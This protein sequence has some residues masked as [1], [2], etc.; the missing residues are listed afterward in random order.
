MNFK[1]REPARRLFFALWPAD[2]ERRTLTAAAAAAVAA[3]GGRAVPEQNLH[4]TL[5]FLGRVPGGR[6]SELAQLGRE[7]AAGWAAGPLVLGFDALAHWAKPQLLCAIGIEEAVGAQSFAAA[8][9]RAAVSE[10]FSPDLKPFRAHVTLARKV[11]HAPPRTPLARI[12]WTCSAL[13]LVESRTS[14]EGSI[15]SV[16]DSSLLGERQKIRKER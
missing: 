8:L 3:S 7:L 15:Y 1:A 11:A 14:A 12:T 13:A 9:K 6:V 4:A 2:E 5:A 10:G 16:V